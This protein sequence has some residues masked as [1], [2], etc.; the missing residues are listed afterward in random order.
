MAHETD[1]NL[2]AL[3]LM[4]LTS[5]N[6]S[7]TNEDIIALC[8]SAKTPAGSPA[9]VCIYPR[10]LPV[11]KK[12]LQGLDL[13]GVKLATVT[14]FPDG[15]DD[16]DIAIAETRAAIAYGADEVDL[17][18]PYRALIAGNET[19]G[20]EM[21]QRCKAVCGEGVCLKVIIESGELET[22]ELIQKACQLTIEGGA[23]FL[24]TS[25]G[26]VPVNATLEATQIM[27]T[28][29]KDSGKDVAFKAAGGIR[30]ADDAKGYLQLAEKL[31]G[32]D[33]ITPDH[34]RFGASSLLNSLL[35]KMHYQ[36]RQ[37]NDSGY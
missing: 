7:D 17:V 4:D 14:N 10:F 5:L 27:L 37:T 6:D 24:K 19:V 25:T 33:W 13:S 15:G 36:D 18:F 11:A 31:M 23:N 29:I 16:I 2:L 34:F 22:P 1:Y 30:T 8:Q 3:S 32:K 21:V 9:A 26:K 20:L 35:A 12:T 28:A